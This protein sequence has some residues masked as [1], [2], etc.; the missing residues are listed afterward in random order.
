MFSY[1]KI[2]LQFRATDTQ[3]AV[4]EGKLCRDGDALQ[5]RRYSHLYPSPHSDH[6]L[7]LHIQ[8]II[9]KK[10]R[11]QGS[12][13]WLWAASPAFHITP[14]AA[15]KRMGNTVLIRGDGGTGLNALSAFRKTRDQSRR[16]EISSAAFSVQQLHWRYWRVFMS[17]VWT[18]GINQTFSS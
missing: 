9:S 6:G 2:Y 16:S 3:Q 11:Q 8:S 10:A 5:S 7:R 18:E 13:M 17:P 4:A 12:F 14:T 15:E 1:K